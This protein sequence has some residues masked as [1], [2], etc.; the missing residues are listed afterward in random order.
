MNLVIIYLPM[1]SQVIFYYP[2]N[3][4]GASQQHS[5]TSAEVDG[6]L[7]ITFV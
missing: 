5:F 1:E 6:D 7:F 3:I 4:S 2:R